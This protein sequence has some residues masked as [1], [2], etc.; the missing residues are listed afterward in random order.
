MKAQLL[1]TDLKRLIAATKEY[2]G[3]SRRFIAEYIRIEF[4]DGKATAWACDG[5]SLSVETVPCSFIDEDFAVY[6]KPTLP[7]GEKYSNAVIELRN[8]AAYINVDGNITGYMQ[9]SGESC[10]YKNIISEI[11]QRGDPTCRI[12]FNPKILIKAIKAAGV[13]LGPLRGPLI[14][15]LRGDKDPVIIRT[16]DRDCIRVALPMRV[17]KW[18]DYDV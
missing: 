5:Y 9:P 12:G 4:H 17:S 18:E 16:K 11:E 1:Y 13:S 3:E 14:L 7:H 15:E 10:D 6:V 8:N 2:I